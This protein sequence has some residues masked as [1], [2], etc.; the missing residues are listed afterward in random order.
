MLNPLE[1]KELKAAAARGA[2]PDEVVR[3]ARRLMEQAHKVKWPLTAAEALKRAAGTVAKAARAPRGPVGTRI[4]SDEIDPADLQLVEK[5]GRSKQAVVYKCMQKSK[6]RTLAVK[7]LSARAAADVEARNSFIHESRNAARLVHPNIVRIWGVAPFK[8]T[9][10]LAMEYVDG[11]S[12]A[13]LLAARQRLEPREA[14]RII[15][16]A[17][18]G[19]AYAHKQG[20]IHR[21]IKPHNILLGRDGQVK[22]ADMGI[23][24]RNADLEAAFAE[25]GR[26]YGTPYY[27]SPEQ[28]RGDPDT[29]FRADIYSLGA[30][31]YQMLAGRPPFASPDPQSLYKMHLNAPVPDPR[32]FVPELPES[33]FHILEKALAK[34]PAD[35]F[36]NC[37]AFIKALDQTALAERAKPPAQPPAQGL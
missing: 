22:I 25:A 2:A 13:D 7:I 36:P 1:E 19:L 33:L 4:E 27:L 14:V 17:A 12:V 11:G 28:V 16:A 24:R 23:A 21:D 6:G 8:D 32:R 31:F 9:L 15:R 37:E 3:E 5:I 29:D 26:A 35:R 10:L 18:E 30:T 20:F 34:K